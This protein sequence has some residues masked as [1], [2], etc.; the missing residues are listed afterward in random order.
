MTIDGTPGARA[1]DVNDMTCREAAHWY[2]DHGFR[3]IPWVVGAEG[4][5]KVPFRGFHFNDYRV[6][7]EDI[8]A[9][10]SHWQVGL[11]MA[12]SA[13]T[14]AVDVDS[15]EQLARWQ[16]SYALSDT[17]RQLSGRDDGGEHRVYRLTAGSE[18]PRDGRFGGGF[19]KLEIVSNGFIAAAPSVH[20]SGRRYVYQ[21]GEVCTPGYLLELYLGERAQAP[22]RAGHTPGHSRGEGDWGGADGYG[23]H[24][25]IERLLAVGIEDA[26]HDDTLA[27]VVFWLK[28]QGRS[29]NEILL[30]WSAIAARSQ[31]PDRPFTEDDFDR[32]WRGAEAKLGEIE[33]VVVEPWMLK[34]VQAWQRQEAQRVQDEEELTEANPWTP[35]EDD[36]EDEVWA[37]LRA[38]PHLR[39]RAQSMALSREAQRIVEEVLFREEFQ[40]P[41]SSGLGAMLAEPDEDVHYRIDGLWPAGGRVML[42]AQYKAGKTT[43][44]DNLIRS[45]A[46]GDSFLDEFAV[47]PVTRKIVAIDFEMSKPTMRRWIRQQGVRNVDRVELV[48]MRGNAAS[49]NLMSDQVFRYWVRRLR[50]LDAGVVILDCLRPILDAIGLDEHREAGRFLTRFDELL[51]EA[52]VDEAVVI[53]HMGH[54]GDRARGDS[55]LRDWPDAEW[56]LV[57][58]DEDDPHSERLFSAIGRDVDVEGHEL[59]F[60]Q[61]SR[62]LIAGDEMT[63]QEARRRHREEQ[64]A[65]IDQAA[66]L[67]RSA[68]DVG[69]LIDAVRAAGNDGINVRRLRETLQGWG[70]A[71]LD[72]ARDLAVMEGAITSRP[73]ARNAVVYYLNE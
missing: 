15:Y 23:E 49:F 9:W 57:R 64:E 18:W 72:R 55:R 60:I 7:H 10:E 29:R 11:V 35:V 27:R 54:Q 13:G 5:K 32:H 61:E 8:D 46:D 59:T 33:P 28:L 40:E 21:G 38:N 42:S 30:V 56:R 73:G 50:A 26:G 6:T 12:K 17:W 58:V 70:R 43:L 3:P 16:D 66:E 45:L 69:V 44:R 19:D 1:A 34:V 62:R 67:A 41:E 65:A 68:G 52:G 37:K 39:E 2:L 36:D 24:P 4:Q 63:I 51:R 71:R 53:H 31:N 47:A 22:R 48:F 14:F 20:P 25:N